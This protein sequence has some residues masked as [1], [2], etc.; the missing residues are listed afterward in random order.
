MSSAPTDSCVQQLSNIEI[1]K[2]VDKDRAKAAEAV[3]AIVGPPI[4]P[5]IN[6]NLNETSPSPKTRSDSMGNAFFDWI[7]NN[8][9]INKVAERAKNSVD[10]MI[11]T[12]DPGMKEIIC[13]LILRFHQIL[14]T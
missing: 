10:S 14:I 4:E 1:S 5:T 8:D 7:A 13:N 6:V 3:V 12:L 11:T 2:S 9:F